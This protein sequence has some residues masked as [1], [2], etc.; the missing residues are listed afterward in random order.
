MKPTD[1]EKKSLASHVEMCALRYGELDNRLNSIEL[2]VEK[3]VNQLD[4]S[5]N[6]LSKVIIGASATIVAGILSTIVTIIM[7]F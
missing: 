4:E 2:K 7:K 3:L 1:I 5:K 6:G